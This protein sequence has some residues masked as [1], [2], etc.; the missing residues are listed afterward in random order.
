MGVEK[1]KDSSDSSSSDSSSDDYDSDSDSDS[2][3]SSSSDYS[4]YSS[5][6]SSSSSSYDMKKKKKKKR[7]HGKKKKK[8]RKKKHYQKKTYKK[9]YK[10]MKN[11]VFIGKGKKNFL[12]KCYLCKTK[13]KNSRRDGVCRGCGL[14]LTIENAKFYRGRIKFRGRRKSEGSHYRIFESRKR[15]GR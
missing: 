2:S 7:K 5:G 4:S 6:S 1:I 9:Y 10:K 11:S 8:K 13:V 14:K 3:S 15:S 12:K